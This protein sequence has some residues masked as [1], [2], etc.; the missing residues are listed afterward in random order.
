MKKVVYASDF[1]KLDSNVYVGGGTD[2][3]E[4]LQKALDLALEWGSLHLIVDGAALVSGLEVHSNTTIECLNSSCG[5]YLA[6][7]SDCPVLRNSNR[8]YKGYKTK[9]VTIQGGT[10]NHNCLHQAHDVPPDNY[11][12]EDSFF[13]P[14]SDNNGGNEFV[15]AM[16]F[17]GI[18][19][20]VVRDITIRDQRTFAFVGGNFR[21]MY[22]ENVFIELENEI[23]CGNQDGF[24]FWGPGQYLTVKNVGGKTGDDFMNIGPDERDGVSAITDVIID[25]VYFDDAWQGIRLLS[26]E[27]GL[28]DRVTIR[29]VSGTYSCFGFYINPWFIND[30]MGNFG[31]ISFENINLKT[32]HNMLEQISDETPPVLFSIGGNFK[33]LNFKNIYWNEPYDDRLLF[34]VGYP[35]YRLSEPFGKVV[36]KIQSMTIDGLQVIDN[37]NKCDGSALIKLRG[38]IERFTLRNAEIVGGAERDEGMTLIKLTEDS[39]VGRLALESV[40]AKN[41]KELICTDENTPEKLV[42]YNV[43]ADE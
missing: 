33:S 26:R 25:G 20:L 37:E 43:D 22:I 17:V 4:V 7:N 40:Y 5:F 21:R 38:N 32:I 30:D 39:N 14:D 27:K 28:L 13:L 11:A 3:T 16:E 2:D 29:N 1:A 24:H 34:R 36:P 42:K 35:F 18:E 12:P 41:I 10:Y 15:V 6:D 19:N 9:N 23:M 8:C 31:T